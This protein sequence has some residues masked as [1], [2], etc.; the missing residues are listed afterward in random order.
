[1]AK[2]YNAKGEVVGHEPPFTED[3]EDE[4]Y[5]RVGGGPVAILRGPKTPVAPF[6]PAPQP[7]KAK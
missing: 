3:E 2:M 1:M 6:P 5:R 7:R 4:F